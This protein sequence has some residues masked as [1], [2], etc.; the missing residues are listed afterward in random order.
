MA[1][2]GPLEITK[3][4]RRESRF[5]ESVSKT[6]A[7]WVWDGPTDSRGYPRFNFNGASDRV[8]RLM[9]VKENGIVPSGYRVYH[10]CRNR[11]CVNPKHLYRGLASDGPPQQKSRPGTVPVYKANKSSTLHVPL[12]ID[13]Q[14]RLKIAGK[15]SAVFA[16][17]DVE[18]VYLEK[19]LDGAIAHVPV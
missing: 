10:R 13:P 6:P 18:G 11:R 17:A 2:L 5:W 14:D 8:H 16:G 4:T 7:C 3:A 12:D 19:I 9:W 1:E 15:A